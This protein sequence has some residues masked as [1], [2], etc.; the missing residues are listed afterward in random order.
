LDCFFLEKEAMIVEAFPLE[1]TAYVCTLQVDLQRIEL[2]AGAWD[3]SFLEKN[4][5][6]ENRACMERLTSGMQVPFYDVLGGQHLYV[7]HVVAGRLYQDAE[8]GKLFMVILGPYVESWK[9]RGA[10]AKRTR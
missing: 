9:Q 4:T 2:H 7:R 8:R 5:P 3:E 1:P 10:T 6:R